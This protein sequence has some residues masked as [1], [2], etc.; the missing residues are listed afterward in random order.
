MKKL[1]IILL[2][3]PL[4][5]C[6]I[7][8]KYLVKTSYDQFDNI[9]RYTL[10]NNILA[11]ESAEIALRHMVC[12]DVSKVVTPDTTKIYLIVRYYGPEYL[13]IQD[14]M[15]LVMLIDGKRCEFEKLGESYN[16]TRRGYMETVS[17][18]IAP[19]QFKILAS[20]SQ[21][22]VKLVGRDYYLDRVIHPAVLTK[23]QRFYEEQIK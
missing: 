23:Y 9:A 20:A 15:S 4:C 7:S 5:S 2:L 16:V 21:V 14:G 1:I 11:A 3:L 8:N 6:G 13:N 18:G 10:T 17:Y 19:E 22:Q 12:L